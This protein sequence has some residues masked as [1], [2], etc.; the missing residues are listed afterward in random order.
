MGK[1]GQN[2]YHVASDVDV[3][4]NLQYY[5]TRDDQMVD[6]CDVLWGFPGTAKEVV[7][8]SGTWYTIRY[9]R[10]VLRPLLIVYPNGDMRWENVPDELES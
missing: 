7:R 2:P 8:G 3:L 10:Q 1:T 6:K 5:L 4:H 9:A